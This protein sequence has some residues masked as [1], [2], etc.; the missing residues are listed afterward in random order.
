MLI[1]VEAGTPHIGQKTT[2]G[3]CDGDTGEVEEV[4]VDQSYLG[5]DMPC[6]NI[7]A[8]YDA[9]AQGRGYRDWEVALKA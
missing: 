6:A 5:L 1:E 9:F 8:L 4:V 7:A 3:I 2:I